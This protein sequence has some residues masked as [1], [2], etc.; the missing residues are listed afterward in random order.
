[1]SYWRT[2]YGLEPGDLPRSAALH[3]RS[4]SL[5]IWQGM[6]NDDIERVVDAVQSVVMGYS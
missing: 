5:P 4:L 2:R 3:S 6:K 1:M